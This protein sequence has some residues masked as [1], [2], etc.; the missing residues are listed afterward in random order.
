MTTPEPPA[1]DTPP[2]PPASLVDFR[3][4]T[5]VDDIRLVQDMERRVWGCEDIDVSPVLLMVALVKSGA[6][7][8]GAFVDRRMR[9]FAF[10]VPGDRRG[11]RLHWSHMTGVEEGL[12]SSGLGTLLKLEQARRVV[13]RGY[14]RIQ[15]TYDPLQS[16]NAYLNLAKLG[17]FADEYAEHVYGDSTSDLHRGAPTDRFIATWDLDPDGTPQRS[18]R[19]AQA[20]REDGAPAGTVTMRGDWHMYHAAPSLPDAPVVRVPIPARFGAMLQDAPDLAL[21]WRLQ[22]RAQ[23]EALF[24]RGYHAVDFRRDGDRGDYIFVR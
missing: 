23:F 2:T 10:S 11:H 4:L 18:P 16:L 21:D 5:S 17:A 9:G 24:A 7:L 22:T 6:L 1:P 14:P 3:K 15:W 12:R 13:A 8:L 20:A 19:L